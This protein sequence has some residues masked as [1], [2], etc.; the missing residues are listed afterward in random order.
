VREHL[1]PGAAHVVHVRVVRSELREIA[2][3]VRVSATVEAARRTVISLE[4]SGVVASVFKREGERAEA[5]EPL[6]A[7]ADEE[8]RLVLAEAEARRRGAQAGVAQAE[9][10]LATLSAQHRRSS[11]LRER[12][13]LSPQ[14]HEKS[15]AAV[16]MAEAALRSARADLELAAVSVQ[17]AQKAL[18]DT[19]A[20]APFAGHV[21]ER[22]L[23]EG[24]LIRTTPPTSA[25]VLVETDPIEIVGAVGEY[26]AGNLRVGLPVD[27]RIDALPDRQLRGELASVNPA[28][29]P[30]TRTAKVRV[31]LP[32]REGDLKPGMA[33]SLLIRVGQRTGIAVPRDA[34]AGLR[35][36]HGRLFVVGDDRK[37]TARDVKVG[38]RE[39]EW[40]MVD[41]DL[42]E[43]ERVIVA[44]Q[45]NLRGGEV[46]AIAENLR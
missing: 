42:R 28:L 36:G 18:R 43:G 25:M 13:I 11:Q 2:R 6:L 45:T 34:F 35:D 39:G 31:K 1:K 29:D 9:A 44:G 23:D 17:R 7:L 19:V 21:V 32:N 38:E 46:V 40:V 20:R 37:A 16:Q 26:D 3:T 30:A 27:I 10:N 41:E 22:L 12:G 15:D 24:A 14:E 8:F 4:V 5:G 33:A